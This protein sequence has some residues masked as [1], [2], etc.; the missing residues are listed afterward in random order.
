MTADALHSIVR[1]LTQ[2]LVEFTRGELDGP[3]LA[4]CLR[5][6]ARELVACADVMESGEAR[7]P[8]PDCG[9]TGNRRVA[10][11]DPWGDVE[12]WTTVVCSFCGGGGSFDPIQAGELKAEGVWYDRG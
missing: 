11:T 7:T 4:A 2:D 12:E 5:E 6:H 9:G 1:A 10:L 3:R 8:C